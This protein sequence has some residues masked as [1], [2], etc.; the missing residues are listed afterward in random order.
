M[1]NQRRPAEAIERYAGD[2][3]PTAKRRGFRL[4]EGI[5]AKPPWPAARAVG[6]AIFGTGILLIARAAV[7]R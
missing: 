6:V 7:L 3:S 2:V 5:A 1:F 4:H